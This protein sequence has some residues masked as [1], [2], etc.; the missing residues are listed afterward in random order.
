[1]KSPNS[2]LRPEGSVSELISSTQVSASWPQRR[3]STFINDSILLD[4]GHSISGF[5]YQ[6]FTTITALLQIRYSSF[7]EKGQ[8]VQKFKQLLTKGMFCK[9]TKNSLVV[10]NLYD[11][12]IWIS[13]RSFLTEQSLQ[14]VHF[15]FTGGKR[16]I[17][18]SEA[19]EPMLWNCLFQRYL[20]DIV[21]TKMAFS[22]T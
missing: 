12:M 20:A 10:T 8:E 9:E 1:M 3:H 17:C 21:Q 5:R 2:L 4:V 11:Y 7:H 22:L 18:K 16:R 13:F 19:A 14:I 6:F 15:S